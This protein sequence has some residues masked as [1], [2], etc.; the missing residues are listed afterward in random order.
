MVHIP[1]YTGP[2]DYFQLKRGAG[3]KAVIFQISPDKA[4]K[5][6]TYG[7]GPFKKIL[8]DDAVEYSLNAE[9]T[10]LEELHNRGISIPRPD[11]LFRVRLRTPNPPYTKTLFQ[12]RFYPGIVMQY[13]DGVFIEKAPRELQ[14]RLEQQAWTEAGKA[15]SAGLNPQAGWDP[16]KNATWAPKEDAQGEDGEIVHKIYL[17]G[18]DYIH[19]PAAFRESPK[20]LSKI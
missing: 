15:I 20:K 11:G 6:R 1:K 2:Q 7:W 17:T 3:P 13:V 18:F 16:R 4:V 9:L 8:H 10:V 12:P 19:A 5:F 14:G